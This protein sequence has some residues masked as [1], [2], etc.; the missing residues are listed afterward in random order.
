ME[1][2]WRKRSLVIVIV[3][4]VIL[5]AATL[6]MLH[7]DRSQTSIERTDRRPPQDQARIEH[8]LREELGF[9][10]GQL[11]QYLQFRR[12]HQDRMRI[13]QRE[14]QDLKIRMFEDVLCDN[15]RPALSESLLQR[16]RQTQ[17]SIEQQTFR[18]LLALRQ[19]CTPDQRKRLQS[20][21]GEMFRRQPTPSSAQLQQGTP[22]RP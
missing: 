10:R 11:A 16:T 12:V 2:L 9:D 4:L 6:L 17:D 21:I 13:L 8:V 20:V 22:E 18:H 15:P 19:L 14:M 1:I 5:N 3:L 7:L